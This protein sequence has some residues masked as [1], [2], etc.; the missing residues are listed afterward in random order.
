MNNGLFD[1][2]ARTLATPMPRRRALR[3]AAGLLVA[4]A[5]PAYRPK[6][7][8][9]TVTKAF[10]GC[11][12]G[13]LQSCTERFGPELP[14]C[15]PDYRPGFAICCKSTDECFNDNKNCCPKDKQCG[16]RCCLPD[17]KCKDGRCVDCPEEQACGETCCDPGEYCGSKRRGL[18]CPKGHDA[19]VVYG[20]SAGLC[21]GPG[22]T[23]CANA[24]SAKCCDAKHPC[25]KGGG[26]CKCAKGETRCG[27]ECCTKGEVC[28]GGKCCPKGNVKC[29]DEC[30]TPGKCCGENCCPEKWLCCSTAVGK[31]CCKPGEHCALIAGAP[32]KKNCCPSSR[33]VTT[34]TGVPLCC[35]TGTID[36]GEN[37]CCPPGNPNCCADLSCLGNTVCVR[38]ECVTAK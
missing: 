7:A 11:P 19:C 16:G 1:D 9:A 35:P 31:K 3:I 34:D 15:C 5:V 36:N 22:T 4:A 2:V 28:S 32:G 18:C 12:K 29:G 27:N 8:A 30:C 33:I 13:G 26:R 14:A 23:C 6:P 20:G 37:D 25:V 10:A 24:K 17:Q 38:G 21:C